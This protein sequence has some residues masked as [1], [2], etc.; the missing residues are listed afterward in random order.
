MSVPV[1]GRRR[2]IEAWLRDQVANGREGDPL[3]S[4]AELA[5]RFDVSRTTARQAV[6]SLAAEGLVH[7][8][9]GSG[10]FVAPQPMHRHSGPLM[11]FTEDMRRRGLVASSRLMS[12]ELR[13]PRGEESK[14]LRLAP[15]QRVVA[16]SRLRLANDQPM[17]IESTALTPDCASVLS[18]D[19]KSGSLHRALRAIGRQPTT[20]ACRISAEEAS[21]AVASLLELPRRAAVLQEQRTVSDQHDTPL[22]FTTT[23][24]SASKYVIDAVLRFAGD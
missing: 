23:I 19:L 15:G 4:E 12:A 7:R 11:S 13:E 17:A 8:Q 24:Y 16:I 3:P 18:E 21:A 6:Q 1:G 9:R 5:E 20:A 2:E 10:T 14:A 22:E